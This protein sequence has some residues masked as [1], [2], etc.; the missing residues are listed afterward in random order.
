[1]AFCDASTVEKGDLIA[2]DRISPQYEGEIYYLAHNSAQQWYY[3]DRQKPEEMVLF[4]SY[5]SEPGNG[6]PCLS[7]GRKIVNWIR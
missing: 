1:M 4:V 2:A 7:D 3:I 5:D 6:P